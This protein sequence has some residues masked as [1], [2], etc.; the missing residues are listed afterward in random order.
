[1]TRQRTMI[2]AALCAALPAFGA[3]A[4]P[5]SNGTAFGDW[6]LICEAVAVNRTRCEIRQ[7]LTLRDSGALLAQVALTPAAGAEAGDAT[8]VLVL[9]T[10]TGMF[11]PMAPGLSIDDADETVPLQWRTCDAN[12]CVATRMLAPGEVEALR[13]GARMTL[14]YRPAAAADPVIFPVSLQG[15]SAALDALAE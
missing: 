4:Q 6:R 15:V 8:T 12:R 9:T 13:D 7:T 3:Q 14:G 10:P 5:A 2:C 11:L 1:M